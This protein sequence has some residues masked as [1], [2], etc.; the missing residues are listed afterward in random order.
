MLNASCVEY[1]IQATVNTTNATPTTIATIGTASPQTLLITIR[2][3]ARQTTTTNNSAVYVLSY[4]AKNNGGILT[5]SGKLGL[6][7]SEDTAAW[8]VNAVVSGQ[9]VLVQATGVAAQT[10]VWDATI[11]V[12][13]V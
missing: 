7:E 11:T 6:A 4:R 3:A 13:E 1:V 12:D 10:I 5:L 2:C 9:N 8:D